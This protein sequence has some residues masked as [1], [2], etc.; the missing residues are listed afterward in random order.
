MRTP[1]EAA[2]RLILI[3]PVRVTATA[4]PAQRLGT[5]GASTDVIPASGRAALLPPASRAAELPAAAT[6]GRRCAIRSGYECLTLSPWSS[7]DRR[8]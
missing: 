7:T 5:D 2:T 1:D 8:R 4:S 3:A 6:G